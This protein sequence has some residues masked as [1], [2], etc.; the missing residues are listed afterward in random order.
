MPK[1]IQ[2]STSMII[3][4]AKKYLHDQRRE[5]FF[6]QKIIKAW[7]EG[8]FNLLEEENMGR[9]YCPSVSETTGIKI[10]AIRRG[11]RWERGM[12]IHH[13]VG[14]RSKHYNCFAKSVCDGVENIKISFPNGTKIPMAVEIEGEAIE[15]Q[16]DR[17]MFLAFHDGLSRKDLSSWFWESTKYGKEPFIGQIVHFSGHRYVKKPGSEWLYHWVSVGDNKGMGLKNT[18][19]WDD[20]CL[21]DKTPISYEE[22]KDRTL[23]CAQVPYGDGGKFFNAKNDAIAQRKIF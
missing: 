4:Y 16:D 17:Y 18:R 2:N 22:F 10:H 1:L 6:A 14:R 23:R 5:T 8:S 3:S 20:D 13:V 19:G 7:K 15:S 12:I 21:F 9:A 11:N